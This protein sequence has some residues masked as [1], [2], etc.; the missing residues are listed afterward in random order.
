[1]WPDRRLIDLFK[2]E[3]P[4]VQA[5]MAGAMDFELAAA[6]AEAGALGSL[7]SPIKRSAR[8]ASNGPLPSPSGG[9]DGDEGARTRYVLAGRGNEDEDEGTVFILLG[10][11]IAESLVAMEK[12]L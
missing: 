2:V 4:I 9:R 8:A 1:M 12:E 11:L 3:I 10:V 5:P 7:P 6:A